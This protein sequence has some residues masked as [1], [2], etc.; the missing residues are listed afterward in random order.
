MFSSKTKRFPK[1]ILSNN[2]VDPSEEENV[3]CLLIDESFNYIHDGFVR[4]DESFNFLRRESPW[5]S[6]QSLRRQDYPITVGL[7]L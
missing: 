5:G 4:V 6:S 2:G 3:K 1:W 7:H